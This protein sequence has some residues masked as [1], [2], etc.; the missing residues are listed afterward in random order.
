MSSSMNTGEF[1]DNRINEGMSD[2]YGSQSSLRCDCWDFC[3]GTFAGMVVGQIS[4]K[5]VPM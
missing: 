4:S 5:N 2:A 3:P 1:V